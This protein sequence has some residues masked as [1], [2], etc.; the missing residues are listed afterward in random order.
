MKQLYNSKPTLGLLSLL[1]LSILCLLTA[2]GKTTSANSGV[3]S[4]MSTNNVF[5]AQTL[6]HNDDDDDDDH[7][8][9]D[10]DHENPMIYAYSVSSSEAFDI[11]DNLSTRC[12]ACHRISKKGNANGPG[13][14]LNGLNEY[15]EERVDGLSAREYVK[16]SILDP[17]AHVVEE[18]PKG[19]CVD[20]MVKTYADELQGDDLEKLVNYLLSLDED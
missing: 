12:T 18:C 8:D 11:M 4:T 9:D 7:D 17:G 16:Q 20:V 15:A 5:K 19:P 14:N 1:S 6:A 3:V 10:D 2:C 13:P